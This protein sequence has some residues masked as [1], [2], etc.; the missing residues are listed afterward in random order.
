VFPHLQI[1][2]SGIRAEEDADWKK[3]LTEEAALKSLLNFL[4]FG[5]GAWLSLRG[6]TAL[7][8]NSRG[9]CC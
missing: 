6:G 5:I 9:A 8:T 4:F 7:D 2:T 3:P 1:T